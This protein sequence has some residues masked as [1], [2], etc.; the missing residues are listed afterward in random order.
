M[1]L[2]IRLEVNICGW[3]VIY[4]A[5]GDVR[6]I[7]VRVCLE[8]MGHFGGQRTG[9]GGVMYSAEGHVGVTPGHDMLV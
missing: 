3:E 6:C 4:S 2:E 7:E 9:L 1:R 8:H 5:R